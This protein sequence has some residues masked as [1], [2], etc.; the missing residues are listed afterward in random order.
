[1]SLLTSY[2]SAREGFRDI[3]LRVKNLP[4]EAVQAA[5]EELASKYEVLYVKQEGEGGS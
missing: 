1:V 2:T 4:P 5:K 3:F